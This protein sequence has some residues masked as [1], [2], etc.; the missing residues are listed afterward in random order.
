MLPP[1]FG[2]N[3]G[4]QT[5][6]AAITAA[7]LTSNL[8]LCLDAGDA[9]SYTSGQSWLDR[10]GNGFD[11]F[12]G[13]TSGSDATDPT[14]NGAAGQLGSYWSSDGGDFFTYDT[15]LEAWMQNLHK[16]NAAFTL[17]VFFRKTSALSTFYF[18]GDAHDG[19][20]D[21]GI[22]F[23]ED[24]LFGPTLDVYDGAATPTV[25]SVTGDTGLAA[26]QWHMAAVSLNEATGAGGGFLYTD[27][28]YNQVSASDT[29]TSTYTSPTSSAAS[30][31]LNIGAQGGGS[32]PMPNN[33]RIACFAAWS[34]ALTKANLDAIWARM[35]V[36]FG[37]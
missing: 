6:M 12:R 34:A 11:F 19:G 28:S 25:L 23:Y 20:T 24:L 30:R 2:G 7:G 5:L 10:S 13:T 37:K 36:R 32:N 29:F 17:L 35:R 4:G 27:G 22:N 31:T 9:A 1:V 14:F 3:A 15:T 26:N 8:Q 21:I 16:D 18:L 33:D